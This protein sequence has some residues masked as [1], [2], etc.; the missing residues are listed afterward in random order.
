MD[1]TL[2]DSVTAHVDYVRRLLKLTSNPETARAV[3]LVLTHGQDRSAPTVGRLAL[4]GTAAAPRVAEIT[5]V[6]PAKITVSYL[7][8]SAIRHGRTMNAHN[9]HPIHLDAW[10]DAYREQAVARW[11]ANVG[12]QATT[13]VNSYAAQHYEWAVKTQAVYRAI[14]HCP[15]VAFAPIR[16]T[17]IRRGALVMVPENGENQ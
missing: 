11:Y 2:T 13:D 4:I 8:D 5:K 10:P 9:S 6:T 16:N 1:A 3:H 15:W 7:T 14:K 12:I 17:T